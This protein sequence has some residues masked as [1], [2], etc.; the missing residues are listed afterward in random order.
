MR[1]TFTRIGGFILFIWMTACMPDPL[2]L[3]DIP[4]VE[5]E[6]VVASQMLS[7][8]SVLILLTKTFGALEGAKDVEPEE[9]LK[10]IVVN[11]ATV[12]IAGAGGTDTLSFRENGV[13]V[14]L[15]L[16]L[17]A[18]ETYKLLV[19]SETM[20]TVSANTTVQPQVPFDSLEANLYYK[21]LDDTLVQLQYSF[22]DPVTENWY[23]LNAQ[24]VMQQGF[25]RQAVNPRA[26]TLLLSDTAFE[27]S[28][29]EENFVFFPKDFAPGDT[30]AVSLS[31]ISQEYYRF[32][33]LRMD[34][35][36]SF[37]EFLS[38]PAN[39][40][41]NVKGGKGFFNLY[42]PD[43]RLLVLSPDS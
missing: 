25:T 15:D 37:L 36:L 3:E 41:S 31:N 12:I 10:Q 11:D 35:R 8:Q 21:N 26:Y 14:G 6:I 20:G 19:E 23:M 9:L 29:Y 42:I 1:K 22:R 5:P 39:Y 33:E 2:E 34:N 43:I 30:I 16:S 24:K 32:M 7:E 40:P 4:D 28:L 27:E 13:Y 17:K 18:G 38:E